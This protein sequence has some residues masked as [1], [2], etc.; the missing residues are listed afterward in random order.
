[1]IG[2]KFDGCDEAGGAVTC[3]FSRDGQKSVVAWAQTGEVAY[4]APAGTQLV[5][6]PL[7]NCQES[8][9]AAAITLTE[10]PVRLYL[11]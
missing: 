10:I 11:Q 7:A 1:M 3:N 4:T 8:A 5:C 2:S 6:D 9:A